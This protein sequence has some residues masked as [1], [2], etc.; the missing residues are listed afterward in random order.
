MMIE[1]FNSKLPKLIKRIACFESL[2]EGELYIDFMFIEF[3]DESTIGLEVDSSGENILFVYKEDIKKSIKS[4]G[5]KY[6]ERS[7]VKGPLLLKDVVYKLSDIDELQELSFIFDLQ[8]VN[9][10]LKLDAFE[11]KVNNS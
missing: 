4:T 2:T 6:L 3:F 1:I 11:I 9:V 8:T 7:V 10:S 5:I